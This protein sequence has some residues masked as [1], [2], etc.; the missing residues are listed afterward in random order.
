[1]RVIAGEF[2][3]RRLAAP[4]G[5]ETR[6]TPDRVRE[7]LF[8][9]IGDRVVGARV[10]DLYAGSGA[11]AIE[12]LSRGAIYAEIVDDARSACAAIEGNLA[13]LGC[14]DRARIV[15]SDVSRYL[16]TRPSTGPFDLITVDAPYTM[17]RAVAGEVAQLLAQGGWLCE[18][19]L[20]IIEHA[21]GT[22]LGA[23]PGLAAAS[24]RRYGDTAVSIFEIQEG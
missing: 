16:R 18:E 22:E 6:P 24:T 12:A 4:K 15:C 20:V 19:A 13:S 17:S 7:A 3:G 2:K 11:L 14:A 10:L 9:I 8:S 1:V 23:L 5:L 21:H